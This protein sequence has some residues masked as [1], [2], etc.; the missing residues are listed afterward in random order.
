MVRSP[1]GL[2]V[3]ER[4]PS[5]RS[6]FSGKGR[7]LDIDRPNHDDSGDFD[8]MYLGLGLDALIAWRAET[9]HPKWQIPSELADR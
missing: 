7:T 4:L 8:P 6:W 2:L 9:G 3:T 5:W 1:L